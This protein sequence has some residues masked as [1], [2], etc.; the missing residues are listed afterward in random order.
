MSASKCALTFRDKIQTADPASL[1]WCPTRLCKSSLRYAGSAPWVPNALPGSP[2]A[3]DFPKLLG[4]LFSSSVPLFICSEFTRCVHYLKQKF[5]QNRIPTGWPLHLSQNQQLLIEWVE[6]FFY[7][8]FCF[9]TS[10]LNL[11]S[12]HVNFPEW[13]VNDMYFLKIRLDHHP[14]KFLNYFPH[15]T[16]QL[17]KFKLFECKVLYYHLN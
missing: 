7:F 8:V 15:P 10:F 5:C 1:G 11:E 16:K 6:R 13:F 4:E 12:E 3:A 2:R 14:S 9:F 17:H